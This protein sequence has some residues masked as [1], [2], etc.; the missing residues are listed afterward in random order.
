MLACILIGFTTAQWVKHYLLAIGAR[1]IKMKKIAI[2]T[3]PLK[4]IALAMLA[5]ILQGVIP[6]KAMAGESVLAGIGKVSNSGVRHVSAADALKVL[7]L[8][9]NVVILD[10]RTPVEFKL[11]RLAD[12]VNINYY[13]FS[14][15]NRIRELDRD[16]TYLLHCQTG[17]RSGRSI[18]IMLAEGFKNVIHMDGGYKS[19]KDQGL[20]VVK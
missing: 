4:F 3:F 18:P 10:V 11:G 9:P 7:E 14:F 19:W 13:S 12:A 8:D 20:P 1:E 15:K 6:A 5:L 2:N 16:K 17:V